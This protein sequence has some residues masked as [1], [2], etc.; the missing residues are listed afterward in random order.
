MR[1]RTG[2]GGPIVRTRR[3]LMQLVAGGIV[4]AVS[5]FPFGQISAISATPPGGRAR[6]VVESD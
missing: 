1:R 6:K 2:F 3:R 5:G 4:C